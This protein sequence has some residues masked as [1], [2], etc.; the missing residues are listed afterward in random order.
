MGFRDDLDAIIDRLPESPQRQTFL[1]SATVSRAVEQVARKAL[2]K[3]SQVYINCVP[4]TDSPVHAHVPQ[5]HTVLSSPSDQ[6]PHTLKLLIHDQFLHPGSSKVIVFCPTTKMTQLITTVV[7]EMSRAIFP[8]RKQ[9]RV[10]EIHSKLT[11]AQRTRASER[12]RDEVEGASILVTSDV[13]ARGVDYP[14]VTRVIQIGVPAS[15]EQYIHR[16][17]R[18]GRSGGTVGRGD[19]VLLPWEIGFLKSLSE[20]PLK[21]VTSTDYDHQLKALVERYD[22]DQRAFFT[23]AF[24]DT[25][26]SN[27]QF[28]AVTKLYEHPYGKTLSTLPTELQSLLSSLDPGA[29]EDT[30]SAMLGFY[31]SRTSDLRIGSD[32]IVQGCK[33]WATGAFA[34]PYP[35]SVS[36]AFL[37]RI[38][39]FASGRGKVA[40][41][42]FGGGERQSSR[43][44]GGGHNSSSWSDEPRGRGYGGGGGGGSRRWDDEPRTSDFGRSGG[45]SSRMR[46][47]RPRDDFATRDFDGGDEGTSRRSFG[48]SK[49]QATLSGRGNFGGHGHGR[50]RS[51][52]GS[53][54][55]SD[56][57]M[58]RGSRS[59]SESM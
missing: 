39:A 19:L 27:R 46:H 26:M 43:R 52:S 17:G 35:P 40:S 54:S 38:G 16:V 18:T 53:D 29:V 15:A 5:Y 21:P 4:D 34:L 3:Q 47:S 57:W 41:R 30:F 10:Y 22:E 31:V 8:T 56:R 11:Q 24:G 42:K 28:K 59:G 23:Q 45:S 13:S 49:T 14:N 55:P 25:E 1:F 2:N 51:G 33:D 50:G 58:G 48:Y 36:E 37:R 44:F 9:T 20:V 32:A 12:F 7:K 6:L